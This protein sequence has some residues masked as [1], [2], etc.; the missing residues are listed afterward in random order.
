VEAADRLAD[1]TFDDETG[2]RLALKALA[3]RKVWVAWKPPEKKPLNPRTGAAASSTDAATWGT[4]A[5]AES[6]KGGVGLVLGQHAGIGVCLGGIDLDACRDAT[7]GMLEP[8]ASDILS[9]VPSYAEVS[10]SRKGVKLFFTYDQGDLG[11][12]QKAMGNTLGKSWKRGKGEHPPAIEL[13]LGGRYYTVTG[14]RLPNVPADLAAMPAA[15]LLRVIN[16][17][18]PKFAQAPDKPARNEKAQDNSRS[19]I[20]WRLAYGIRRKGGSREDFELALEQKPELAEWAKNPRNVER[21]WNGKSDGRAALG[22]MT[23]HQD[24][25]A[26]AF[27]GRH[28]D[29]RFDVDA[30]HWRY[31]DGNHWVTGKRGLAFH[32]AR[33]LVRDLVQEGML[34]DNAASRSTYADIETIAQ[35]D[36]AHEVDSTVWNPDKTL[37]GT[38]NGTIESTT[39]KLREPRKDDMITKRTSVAPIALESF[40]PELDCPK[41]IAF[42]NQATG[43]DPELIRFLQQ[44]CGYCLTGL[45]IEHALV[46]IYGPGG[47]GKSV[48]MNIICD[49]LGDYAVTAGMDVFTASKSDRHPQELARLAGVRLVCA[50]ET[51]E[52]R[53]WDE[54]RI[55]TMTGGD[56]IT[57]RFMRQNDFTF[58]PQFKLMIA[59][60]NRPVLRNVDDAMRRR[61]NIVPFTRKPEKPDPYLE[62]KLREER[63]GILS[64]MMAGCVDWHT[65]RLARPE[66][67]KKATAG[68]FDEQD[69]FGQ[70]IEERC[71]EGKGFVATTAALMDDWRVFAQSSGEPNSM[72]SRSFGARL[73]ARG[74]VQIKDSNGIRGRGFRGLRPKPVTVAGYEDDL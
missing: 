55:K 56:P 20:A 37:N 33:K 4:L 14:E 41:W 11:A 46:F 47:N 62:S 72:T 15:T 65:N 7:T 22:D 40:D 71:E 32:F 13:H 24:G 60:N 70:W 63:A 8:W 58:I 25:L 50:S 61:I 3:P 66:V 51:T 30:G 59:G 49:I 1:E 23:P 48:F 28:P 5:Q 29:T 73:A 12:L 68:Y 27:T 67:V 34:G 35:R 17:L 39:G 10:P 45:T 44:W 57:A 31:F 74:F 18:G 19:G 69:V 26:R 16:H 42:L 2:P 36:P 38:P 64:W 53:A 52:G 43:N 54:T 9:A 21:A 6:R